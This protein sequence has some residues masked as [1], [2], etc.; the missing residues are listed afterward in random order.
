QWGAP[1]HLYRY[2]DQGRLQGVAEEFN[3]DGTRSAEFEYNKDLLVRYR[4]YHR[5]GR[6][7]SEAKRVKGKFDLKGHHPD[8]GVRVE[9]TYLDEGAKDGVWKYYFPDGTLDS[10]ESHAKGVAT[11]TQY[12]YRSDGT[13]SGEDVAYERNGVAYQSY[14]RYYPSGAVRQQGQW[15]GNVLEGVV[16]AYH[17]DGNPESVNYY[18]NGEHHGW[19]DYYDPGGVP[20][21]SERK[22]N[23]FLLERVTYDGEGNEY[24]RVHV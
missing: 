24:E 18:R 23:G 1:T 6:V 21:Y 4:F 15:K 14:T 17:P 12:H 7:L 13:K 16:R 11:G 5:D 2:D 19:Q 22:E 3:G 10:E 9:G 8:G 20:H